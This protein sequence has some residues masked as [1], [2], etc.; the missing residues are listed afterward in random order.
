[1]SHIN[2]TRRIL[3]WGGVMEEVHYPQPHSQTEEK[4]VILIKDKKR[5]KTP[6][7]REFMMSMYVPLNPVINTSVQQ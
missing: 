4:A 5:E 6:A 7:N 3:T 2:Y 1:M